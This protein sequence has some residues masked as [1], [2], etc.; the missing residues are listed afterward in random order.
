MAKMKMALMGTDV[1]ASTLLRVFILC[2]M[3]QVSAAITTEQTVL[4]ISIS[5]PFVIATA[6]ITRSMMFLWL[7]GGIVIT[8]TLV[9]LVGVCFEPVVRNKIIY[10]YAGKSRKD[11]KDD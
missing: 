2:W 6:I 9:V 10:R 4:L 1:Q 3:L 5:T 11:D 8:V 7:I